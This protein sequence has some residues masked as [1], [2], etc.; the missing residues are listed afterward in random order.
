MN[1]VGGRRV[2]WAGGLAAGLSS[3]L[4]LG[5][6]PIAFAFGIAVGAAG[7]TAL[8]FSTTATTPGSMD[9]ASLLADL[10][11]VDVQARHQAA[12]EYHSMAAA[13]YVAV[14]AER[15]PGPMGG[16]S[17][18]QRATHR[19]LAEH[20]EHLRR[21]ML[22]TMPPAGPGD[23]RTRITAHIAAVV[24]SVRADQPRPTLVIDVDEELALAW[25]AETSLLAM[26]R[27]QLRT[28]AADPSVGLIRVTIGIDGDVVVVRVEHDRSIG[29]IVER[30]D[31][32]QAPARLPAQPE[33]GPVRPKL[34]L[35]PSDGRPRSS[36]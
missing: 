12:T 18:V 17:P 27:K 33:A 28:S 30:L 3:G 8:G 14:A 9:D 15:V 4:M 11:D 19:E 26:L 31:V 7:A 10:V 25:S 6:S 16:T 35:V 23:T 29:A 21:Q 22:A 5:Q 20:V 24:A 32:A 13:A 34:R 36:A 2:L 1:R